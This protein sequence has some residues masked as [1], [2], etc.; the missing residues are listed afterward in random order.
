MK[1]ILISLFLVSLVWGSNEIRIT[2]NSS[3]NLYSCIRETDGDVWH[4]ADQKYEVWGTDANDADDYDIPLVDKSGNFYIGDFNTAISAGYYTIVTYRREGA[5]AADTDPALYYENGYWDGTNWIGI[6]DIASK[7][8]TNYIIGS[9]VQGDL[10]TAID[11]NFVALR[12]AMDANFSAIDFDTSG[13]D[14]NFVNLR[15]AMDANFVAIPTKEEIRAEIDANSTQLQD[16]GSAISGLNDISISDVN[17]AV[18]NRLNLYDPPTKTEMDSGFDSITVDN[19][20]IAL[21]VW[22]DICEGSYSYK[23]YM[24]EMAAVL[25]GKSTGGGTTTIKFKDPPT[26]LT[27]RVTATV[28]STGNRTS[29]TLEPE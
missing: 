10:N 13:I 6:P 21:A 29:V 25:F 22:D 3:Y 16:I 1:K 26:G 11:A 27:D 4:I 8:P 2:Y 14:A 20:A 12:T 19:D 23:D 24:R 7:L 28:D 17:T 9:S 18:T 15:T 5:S